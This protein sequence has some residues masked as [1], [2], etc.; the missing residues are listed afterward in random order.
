MP[1]QL[2]T[3]LFVVASSAQVVCCAQAD[4]F[5]HSRGVAGLK[6]LLK[7]H[8]A[9]NAVNELLASM[10]KLG[11]NSAQQAPPPYGHD[12]HGR[13]SAGTTSTKANFA[14][15]TATGRVQAF[16]SQANFDG[17]AIS[18][19]EASSV[20][21]NLTLETKTINN[22]T[23][24]CNDW[25]Q[26]AEDTMVFVSSNTIAVEV[27]GYGSLNFTSAEPL[28]DS[29]FFYGDSTKNVQVS[30]LSWNESS[31]DP[32]SLES[33]IIP[34]A[35]NKTCDFEGPYEE[36]GNALFCV[37]NSAIGTKM[38]VWVYQPS[39]GI[40][41]NFGVIVLSALGAD[42]YAITVPVSAISGQPQ[43]MSNVMS[44][45]HLGSTSEPTFG[46]DFYNL[47]S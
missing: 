9:E 43:F 12:G 46:I 36:L 11:G 28:L 1:S 31:F 18:R 2:I 20:T 10:R 30:I 5:S 8:K 35:A 25:T 33:N 45:Y 4:E 32:A 26:V 7:E 3:V 23:A 14:A 16:E 44:I 6:T 13:H 17:A 47:C 40:S 27:M 37:I 34:T 22:I 39:D 19:V 21:M 29:Y 41:V 42:G 24:T 38:A 15:G